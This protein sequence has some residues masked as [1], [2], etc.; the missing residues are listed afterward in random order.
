MKRGSLLVFILMLAFCPM[1]FGQTTFGKLAG[2]VTDA[3][4]A[5]VP[6]AHVALTNLGTTE[7]RVAITDNAGGY[8]FVDLIPGQYRIDVEVT[9]FKHFTR[10]PVLIEVQQT[11]SIDIALQL[12]AVTQTVE[13]TAQT[14]LLQPQTSSL[15][16]VVETRQVNELPLNGRN[17]MNLVALAPSVVP[18]GQALGTPTGTNPFAWG[19]YQIGGAITNQGAEYLDGS[20]L[21]KTY[22]NL[23]SLVPT[24]DSLQ[25]F[26]VQTNN[27]DAEWGRFAGGVVNFTTKAGSND[28]HGVAYEYLRNTVLNAN[29]WFDN[30]DGVPRAPFVQN[31]FGANAGGPFYIPGLYDGR[32]KT[33]WFASYEGFRQRFGSPWSTT[34]PTAAERNG[35]YSSLLTSLGSVNGQLYDPTTTNTTTGDSRTPFAGNIIP[36]SR[37]NPTAVAMLKYL[38]LPNIPGLTNQS[39]VNNWAGTASQGGDND[40]LVVRAD[41]NVS[42]KQRFFARYTYWSNLNIPI[43]PFKTGYCKDRCTEKFRV[44]DAVFDQSYNFNPTTILD[45]RVTFNRFKYDR[46]PKTVGIDLSQFG[47]YYAS[48]ASEVVQDSMP[49][50]CFSNQYDNGYIEC[51]EG[52][53]SVIAAREDTER[54]AGSLTK[55][56]GRHTIQFGGEYRIDTDNY[57]QTNDPIGNF[58]F[59]NAFTSSN[60][61]SGLGGDST[62]SFLLGYMSGTDISDPAHTASL[63]IYPALYLQDQFRATSK[64][65]LNYG[66]RWE[67][68]GPETERY[69]RISVLEPNVATAVKAGCTTI[70][71]DAQT[72]PLAG[73]SQLCMP[74][75]GDLG[76]VATPQNPN[77]YSMIK[78]WK[79]WSPHVGLAYKVDNKTVIRGGYGIFWI[80]NAVAWPAPETDFVNSGS[81]PLV[82]SVD[83]GFTPCQTPSPTGCTPTL[84]NTFNLYDPYRNGILS[85][86]GRNPVYQELAYGSGIYPNYP[87][88]PPAY[89]QQW[90]VDVQRELPGGTLIDVAYAAA[91]GQHLPDYA[92]NID[93]LPDKYL[94]LGNS[95]LD[96]VP[97][98]Y[99]GL[100]QT[101]NPAIQNVTTLNTSPTVQLQ[102]LLIPYP[103]YASYGIDASDWAGSNYQ[104]MQFK[105]EKRMK[106][107]GTLLVAYTLSKMITTG[108]IDSI[109][110]WLE[111]SP[112]GPG[113]VQDWNDRA[114][115]KSLSSYDVPQRLVVSYVLDLPVGKGKRFLGNAGGVSGKLIS[116]WG[117]QGITT[118]QSGFPLVMTGGGTEIGWNNGQRPTRISTGSGKLSGSADSRLGGAYGPNTWFNTS[119]F[120]YTQ[121][122]TY[123]NASRVDPVLRAQGIQ[124]WDFSLVKSTSFGPENK[125]NLQFR[126]EFF[127]I[128]NRVQFN[129]PN[130]SCC[131]YSTQPSYNPAFGTIGSDVNTPR[132]IQFALRLT[133]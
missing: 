66:I 107:Q 29:D 1:S 117:A 53:A 90:N 35:D 114:N 45:M 133:F 94:S 33:F 82:T 130:T 78:P 127:N 43:D 6:S 39:A 26:K 46:I 17:A 60:P 110:S 70:P 5:S 3:S 115:E 10:M 105:L 27:L 85:A 30:A 22:V 23:F 73:Q 108:D 28:L 111:S 81:T 89:Y 99:Y 8:Q 42:D 7:K 64:L 96:M 16:Q 71:A 84:S 54:V 34:V 59:T 80:S 121:L 56:K 68:T 77:R 98:P 93:A 36:S 58:S 32:N 62:A 69:N 55:I 109:T 47:P 24:Q 104:S 50:P 120:G 4:G 44:Q 19:N 122:W 20:P 123:G 37:F 49:T 92:Q 118:Y 97:N 31:Q 126:A 102:S 116:G 128:F 2:T 119:V 131:S 91:K 106:G 124:N 113:G 15:G 129:A 11:T 9:G 14:P 79:Q 63:G 38:P 132:L 95:L 65:T 61:I 52:T 87:H 88:N 21:N 12:G 75:V 25:E 86:P 57:V 112:A 100:F 83:G 103:Q 48:Y 51:S 101:G 76:L 18:Q 41:Q 67:Q 72:G 74:N 13:V 40:Q 125:L